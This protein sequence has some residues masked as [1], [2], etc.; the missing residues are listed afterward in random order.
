MA[1]FI[2]SSILLLELSSCK[3]FLTQLDHFC[4]LMNILITALQG[5]NLDRVSLRILPHCSDPLLYRKTCMSATHSWTWK[6]DLIP[7]LHLNL[8]SG[9]SGASMF[10]NPL[11]ISQS[12][13]YFTCELHLIT[14]S[15]LLTLFLLELLFLPAGIPLSYVS[16]LFSKWLLSLLAGSLPILK[17]TNGFPSQNESRGLWILPWCTRPC[18]NHSH[19]RYPQFRIQDFFACSV[20]SHLST[21]HFPLLHQACLGLK[22]STLLPSPWHQLCLRYVPPQISFKKV[23]ALGTM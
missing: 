12:S 15:W 2:S 21:L 3:S 19:P 6:S 10:S 11:F 14:H 7:K 13:S 17:S 18:V 1:T 4:L 23:S 16:L 22:T 20:F 8:C 9:S 5:K